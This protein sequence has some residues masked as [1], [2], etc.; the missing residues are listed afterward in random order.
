MCEREK[1]REGESLRRAFRIIPSTAERRLLDF[2]I[3]N[4]HEAAKATQQVR[5]TLEVTSAFDVAPPAA[6]PH[7]PLRRVFFYIAGTGVGLGLRGGVYSSGV[8]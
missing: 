4:P 7:L 8:D 6:R 1:E 3:K 5:T 2:A